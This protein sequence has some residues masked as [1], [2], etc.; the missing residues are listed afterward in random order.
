MKNKAEQF[1]IQFV[2]GAIILIIIIFIGVM[3][4]GGV[5]SY[6]GGGKETTVECKVCHNEYQKGSENA[7]S[8]RK[9]N[10]C[11][12]CYR[13]YKGATDALQELPVN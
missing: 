1:L 8:I 3:A 7:K 6:S 10:M 11:T 5:N 9:T 4:G 13:S 12:G 2:I